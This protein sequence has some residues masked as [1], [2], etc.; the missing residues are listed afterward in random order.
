MALKKVFYRI[1]TLIIY[2]LGLIIFTGGCLL[3]IIN[4]PPVEFKLYFNI[5]VSLLIIISQL[6]AFTLSFEILELKEEKKEFIIFRPVSKRDKKFL[7]ITY[8]IF[9]IIMVSVLIYIW[10]PQLNVYLYLGLIIVALIIGI[11]IIVIIYLYGFNKELKNI[12]VNELFKQ[13]AKKLM[14]KKEELN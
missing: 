7:K 6:G 5:L 10:F 13:R 11:N 2:I 14:Q 12:V 1:I 3:F 8:I 4:F 9:N